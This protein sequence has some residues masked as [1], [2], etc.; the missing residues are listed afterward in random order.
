MKWVVIHEE[1]VSMSTSG[2]DTR[3]CYNCNHQFSVYDSS[4]PECG[5]HH[6]VQ[7]VDPISEDLPDQPAAT[8]FRTEESEIPSLGTESPSQDGSAFQIPA[9]GC[10]PSPGY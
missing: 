1:E 5:A 7:S 4:C 10:P 9:F 2:Q 6:D 8:I 3:F